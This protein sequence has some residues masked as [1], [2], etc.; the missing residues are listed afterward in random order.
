MALH[1]EGSFSYLLVY[2]LP[3]GSADD[4]DVAFIEKSDHFCV[5]A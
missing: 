2:N 5:G 1:V 4:H 3:L